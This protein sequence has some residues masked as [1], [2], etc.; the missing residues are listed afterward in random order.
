[1]KIVIEEIAS[2]GQEEL[3]LRVHR[4]GEELM[5]LVAQLRAAQSGIMGYKGEEAHRLRLTS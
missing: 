4:A 5:Q 1:M 2:D 3:I